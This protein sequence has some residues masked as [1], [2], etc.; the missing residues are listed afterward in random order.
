VPRRGPSA[1][2]VPS[3]PTAADADCL[4]GR[5]EAQFLAALGVAAEVIETPAFRLH[6]GHADDPFYRTVAVPTRR[7]AGSGPATWGSA[8]AAMRRGFAAAGRQPRLE[9]IEE[10]WPDLAPALAAAGFASHARL[11]VMTALPPMPPAERMAGT[12][13]ITFG[14][15]VV[16][17]AQ[18]VDAGESS[19]LATYLEAVHASFG[20]ALAPAVLARETAR[21][22]GDIIAGRCLV[23]L[24]SDDEGRVAAGAS[25][26]GIAPRAT[27]TAELAGVWTEPRC[28]RRGLARAVCRSLLGHFFA[29]GGQLVWLG[30]EGREARALY[31]ALGFRA[32]G[33]QRTF[34]GTGT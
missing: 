26:I 8:I 14:G 3:S 16:G 34:S 21:L 33:W 22:Q 31:A 11:P 29:T 17:A 5:I 15:G 6:I 32:I 20:H 12:M 27:P 9:F 24:S 28:R 18:V 19:L 25:L 10:R 30:A 7:P 13:G 1:N 4:L 2:T 23:A